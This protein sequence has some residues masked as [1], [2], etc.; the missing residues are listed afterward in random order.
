MNTTAMLIGWDTEWQNKLQLA[1][2]EAWGVGR[3]AYMRSSTFRPEWATPS[4]VY[5]A[6]IWAPLPVK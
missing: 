5:G 2:R 3:Q 4:V 1:H 6:A